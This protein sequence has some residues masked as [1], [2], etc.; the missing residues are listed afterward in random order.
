MFAPRIFALVIALY[1]TGCSATTAGAARSAYISPDRGVSVQAVM[2]GLVDAV[3]SYCAQYVLLDQPIEATQRSRRSLSRLSQIESTPQRPTLVGGP[4]P[5]WSLNATGGAVQMGT[6]E[7]SCQVQA[8]GPPARPT[9]EALTR[10]LAMSWEGEVF[11]G[12]RDTEP[13]EAHQRVLI[14]HHEN[15]AVVTIQANDPGAA[16]MLSR[17]STISVSVVRSEAAA[18]GAGLKSAPQTP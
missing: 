1:L 18:L 16:G 12:E 5:V 10:V 4:G 15:R 13:R 17:F 8:Y 9:T 7:S 3:N 6:T 2:Q 11:A 14:S